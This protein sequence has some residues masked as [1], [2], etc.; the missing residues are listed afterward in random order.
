[1]DAHHKI[2]VDSY[3]YSD[4]CYTVGII[5]DDYQQ[6]EPTKIISCYTRQYKQYNAGMFHQR[7]LPGILKLLKQVDLSEFDT[8]IVDANVFIYKNNTTHDGLGKHLY[9]A[10]YKLCEGINII[11]VCKSLYGDD[12]AYVKVFRGRSK[13]PLYITSYNID[14]NVCA[15]YIKHMKGSHRIPRLLK[16]LDDETKKFKANPIDIKGTCPIVKKRRHCS[17]Y[18]KM[19]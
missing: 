6:E 3:Y 18:N 7:E 19:H 9:D 2:A 4:W 11:G 17:S 1:M 15:E 8:I 10:I 12:E 5:F 13:K 16:I 14:T